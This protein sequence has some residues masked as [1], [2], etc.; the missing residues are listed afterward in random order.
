MTRRWR[1]WLVLALL[2]LVG[3][4]ALWPPVRWRVIGWVRGEAFYDGKPTSFWR[5]EIQ[6][7][8]A[9]LEGE[10]APVFYQLKEWAGWQA[11]DGTDIVPALLIVD[12]PATI[13]VLMELMQD[14]DPQV[15]YW[16]MEGLPR[17]PTGAPALPILLK[18]LEDPD[19]K[20]RWWT[21]RKVSEISA[22]DAPATVPVLIEWLESDRTTDDNVLGNGAFP[23][24][25]VLRLK[26]IGPKAHAAVPALVESL[27]R[28]RFSG[29][30]Y[31]MALEALTAIDPET[32]AEIPSYWSR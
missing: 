6:G 13:P 1:L 3:A 25:A 2:L 5:S 32:A 7:Y 17:D 21:A 15:R 31:R 24:L 8:A 23:F 20:V 12:D 11:A 9:L 28:N 26:E 27:Q 30:F 16:A 4:A 18:L 29:T 14:P 19:R 22:E 10:P